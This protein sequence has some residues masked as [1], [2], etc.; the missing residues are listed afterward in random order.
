MVP[1]TSAVAVLVRPPL[2]RRGAVVVQG[3]VTGERSTAFRMPAMVTGTITAAATA[4]GPVLVVATRNARSGGVRVEGRLAA[5][6][7]LRWL[8]SG[9]LGF[10]PADADRIESG[11]VVI[12]GHRFGDGNVAV[13][14]WDPATGARL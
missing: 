9:S 10:D 1:G 3:L 4:G 14:W 8:R 12:L 5:T 13:A 11:V 7:G 2:G 6:G